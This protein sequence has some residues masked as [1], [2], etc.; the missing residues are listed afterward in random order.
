MFSLAFM[1]HAFVASTFIAI[2]SGV[3]G[4]FVVARNMSFLTHTLS[5]IGFAGASFAVFM[6]WSPLNGML[7]FTILSSVMVGQLSNQGSRRE[8]VISATSALFIGLGILFLSLSSQM[9]SSATSILFGSVV[10]ISMHE[11][12]QLII[13]SLIVLLVTV[14]I[15][16]RLKFSSFDPVGASAVGVSEMTIS[17]I[18][19]L[20]LAMSVSVAAQIVGSLLIFILLTLPAA[21]AKYFTHSVFSM[22]LLS[23]MFALLGTWLGLYLGY[24][25][26]CPVSFFTAVLEAAIYVGSLVYHHYQND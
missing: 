20:L 14:A 9:A 23:T 7:L 22:I 1:R 5:E 18:F 2:I 24:L 6:G 16:R 8:A 11:E 10:G 4:V 25:T 26:N 21:S 19:L 13:L 15:Y 17:I 12:R 3:I